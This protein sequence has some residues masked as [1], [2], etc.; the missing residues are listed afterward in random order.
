[1]GSWRGSCRGSPL[2]LRDATV[3]VALCYRPCTSRMSYVIHLVTSQHCAQAVGPCHAM[4]QPLWCC[5]C[6]KRFDT[7]I[8]DSKRGPPSACKRPTRSK[9]GPF[10]VQRSRQI[11]PPQSACYP[12]LAD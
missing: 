10:G 6:S 1:M 11:C 7:S 8:S 9:H 5:F 12:L 3:T 2:T 4:P